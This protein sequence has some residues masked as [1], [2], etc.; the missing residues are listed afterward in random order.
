MYIIYKYVDDFTNICSFS[1]S[2]DF[3]NL[4]MFVCIR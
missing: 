1:L 3:F 2:D 4:Q